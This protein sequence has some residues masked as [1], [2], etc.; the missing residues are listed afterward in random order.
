[1]KGSKVKRA[2][3]VDVLRSR[4]RQFAR[5][6]DWEKFHSPKNLCM[7]LAAEVGELTEQFQW[8]SEK[9]SRGLSDKAKARVAQEL[10]D[11]FIY[12]LRLSDR[13]GIDLLK[14]AARKIEASEAKYPAAKVH[15][16][17]RKYLEYH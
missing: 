10:A 9:Q 6:R 2:L 1:M 5:A 11:V 3:S 16:S 7:A 15:G 13:L 12:L 8:L 4:L 17:A 14:A